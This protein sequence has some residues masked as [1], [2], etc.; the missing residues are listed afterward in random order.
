MQA[1]T[2]LLCVRTGIDGTRRLLEAV[3]IETQDHAK[4][5]GHVKTLRDQPQLDLVVSYLS[6]NGVV[7]IV[8]V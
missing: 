5:Y 4:A 6:D 2:R 3:G 8:L 1:E 7:W